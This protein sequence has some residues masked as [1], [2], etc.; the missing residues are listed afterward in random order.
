MSS[1]LVTHGIIRL[2]LGE[3]FRLQPAIPE[4]LE[5]TPVFHAAGFAGVSLMAAQKSP[6]W[7]MASVN[8]RK[9]NGFTT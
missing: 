9:P 3:D 5:I 2:Q 1:W 8:S 4:R 7:L 6:V